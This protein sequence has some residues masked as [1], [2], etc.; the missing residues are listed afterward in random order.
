MGD[1]LS[2]PLG[3]KAALGMHEVTTQWLDVMGGSA[4]P[5]F[6][7]IQGTGHN[8]RVTFP[9]DVPNAYGGGPPRNTY[10][11]RRR[12]AGGHRRPPASGRPVDRPQG[13]P[14][15]RTVEASARRAH[16]YEP[17]GAVSWDVSMT[18]TPPQMARGDQEG[19]RALRLGDLRLAHDVLVRVDG[20]HAAGHDARPRRR[21]RPFLK[22]SAE[23]ACSPT[24]TCPRAMRFFK[25]FGGFAL[26]SASVVLLE[27]DADLD[28]DLDRT[29][30]TSRTCFPATPRSPASGR[31]PPRIQNNLPDR[32]PRPDPAPAPI[33]RRHARRARRDCPGRDLPTSSAR[34]QERR[35]YPR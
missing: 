24:A 28:S 11:R 2:I 32:W 26:C 23:R 4:Y 31:Y 7:A 35:R 13:H 27:R 16:Y 9:D 5:V 12:H 20:D 1:G 29:A 10:R 8:G 22:N 17:A 15:G 19:R 33:G 3:A 30:A 6:D 34:R 18:A 14:A 25:N 21:R